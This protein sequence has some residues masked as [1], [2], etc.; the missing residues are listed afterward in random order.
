MP[1]CT[2]LPSSTYLAGVIHRKRLN[3][4]VNHCAMSREAYWPSRDPIGTRVSL[5]VTTRTGTFPRWFKIV[6]I[7]G[8]MKSGA[9]DEPFIP[10][11]YTPMLQ[12]GAKRLVVLVRTASSP[13]MLAESLRSE[14]QAV[15]PTLPVFDVRTMGTI[16]SDSL[17]PRR[18]AMRVLGFFAATATLLATIGI[19]E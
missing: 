18:F 5:V 14:I 15:D 9:L 12:L 19:S 6:G 1:S 7:V 4:G 3:C 17:A 10:R 8:K 16:V 11:I 13:D 2:F